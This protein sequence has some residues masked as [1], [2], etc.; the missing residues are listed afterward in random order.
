MD[1][2]EAHGKGRE[3][4]GREWLAWAANGVITGRL[5]YRA[6]GL[7][8]VR[9]DALCGAY[10]RPYPYIRHTSQDSLTFWPQG[11]GDKALGGEPH[12]S[13]SFQ[14]SFRVSI[15]HA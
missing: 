12:P 1:V 14:F 7:D 10:G 9:F 5:L 4:K 3:V 11:S 8:R 15:K 13:E 2:P 6:V